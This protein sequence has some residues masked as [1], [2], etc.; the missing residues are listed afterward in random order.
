MQIPSD[1]GPPRMAGAD[2]AGNATLWRRWQALT[3]VD[4]TEAPDFLEMAAFAERGAAAP[5][6][7]RVERWLASRPE[8]IPERLADIAAARAAD[9]AAADAPTDRMMKRAMDL[10]AGPADG[11]VP[12]RP[13]ASRVFYSCRGLVMQG[14]VAA[15]LVATSL[16]G[17]ALGDNAWTTLVG[18]DQPVAYQDLLDPPAGIFTGLTGDE[19]I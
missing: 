2:R 19:G 17:F 5:E 13:L 9:E 4:E 12:L 1:N 11:I 7:E 14:G 16:I 8:L 18:G 10:V 6:S 3:P 15:V